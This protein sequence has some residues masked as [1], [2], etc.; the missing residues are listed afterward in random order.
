MKAVLRIFINMGLKPLSN[1]KACLSSV[2]GQ[3]KIIWKYH[4]K[5]FIFKIFT[6]QY[7]ENYITNA[8]NGAVFVKIARIIV[9]I[10]C[11]LLR[12]LQLTRF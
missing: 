6:M 8:S 7:V 12:E 2:C 10:V 3:H 5:G 9:G 4:I 11:I 1:I